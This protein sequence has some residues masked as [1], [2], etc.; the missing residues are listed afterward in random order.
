VNVGIPQL[1]FD[2]RS[3]VVVAYVVVF[4]LALPLLAWAIGTRVDVVLDLPRVAEVIP[5]GA[6]LFVGGAAFMVWSMLSLSRRGHGLPISHLPPA[7]LVVRGPHATMRHPIYVGYAAAF[8]GAGLATG[9]LGRGVFAAILLVLGSVAYAIGFEETRLER[10]FGAAYRDYAA[11]VPAFPWPRRAVA[12]LWRAVAPI[13]DRVAN[14][15]VLFRIGPTIWVSY[16]AFAGAGAGIGLGVI[17]LLLRRHVP[18][19]EE[20]LYLGGLALVMLAGARLVALFYAPRL[21][22]TRPGEALRRVGFVSWGG[23]IGMFAAPF[24]LAGLVGKDGWWLLDRTFVGGL[25]CSALGRIGCLAYGC[26]YGR[27]TTHGV[28]WRHPEA[29]VNREH[30]ATISAPRIPTQLLSSASTLALIPPVLVVMSNAASGVAT[31]LG[32]IL[33]CFARFVVECLRDEPRLFGGFTRG[34]AASGIGA[35]AWITILFAMDGRGS[36]AATTGIEPTWAA[37][38]LVVAIAALVFVACSVH[39]KRVGRW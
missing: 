10:R 13:A 8:A 22:V 35:A 4:F 23:Y 33:Y 12:R 34:Q 24:L 2:R 38:A 9:S 3:A 18:L 25:A 27:R 19:G 32:S 36:R 30:P 20:S 26:C 21:L 1:R 29:K 39:W 15:V 31:V 16:G 5:L 28:S 14:R 11:S 7:R 17:H 6:T 37:W